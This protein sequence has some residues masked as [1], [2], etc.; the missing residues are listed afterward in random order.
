MTSDEEK[1][2]ARE[3]KLRVRDQTRA[4]TRRYRERLR[5]GEHVEV[6]EDVTMRPCQSA[7]SQSAKSLGPG[8]PMHVAFET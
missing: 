8:V 4:R 7:L 3:R 5:Q 2:Q 1:R 6:D